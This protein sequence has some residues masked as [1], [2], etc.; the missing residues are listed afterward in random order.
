[1]EKV[2]GKKNTI[3]EAHLISAHGRYLKKIIEALINKVKVNKC[4]DYTMIICQ[5]FMKLIKI[6]QF[7]SKP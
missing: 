1:M 6:D 4:T 2:Q 7:N 5:I 3:K